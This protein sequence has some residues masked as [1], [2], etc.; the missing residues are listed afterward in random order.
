M[1]EITFPDGN[2]KHYEGPVSGLQVALDISEGLARAALAIEV[3]G[4]LVDI[5]TTITTNANVRI[6]TFRDPEG[7]KLFSLIFTA[8]SLKLS[9]FN[10]SEFLSDI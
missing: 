3:D 9:T 8:L 10:S 6:I 1:V 7:V 4:K 5:T 2:K